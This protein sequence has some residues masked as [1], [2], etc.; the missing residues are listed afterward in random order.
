LQNTH[1]SVA[2]SVIVP[3]NPWLY[4]TVV[5]FYSSS[6]KPNL[7]RDTPPPNR[8]LPIRPQ[9]LLLLP[10]CCGRFAIQLSIFQTFQPAIF[11][12]V[13][14]AG[15]PVVLGKLIGKPRNARTARNAKH[16]AS[17]ASPRH[18]K[19]STGTSSTPARSTSIRIIVGL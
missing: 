1:I 15:T 19:V 11:P 8:A 14:G 7:K 18:P 3:I 16:S 5:R 6:Q 17:T 9:Q 2:G 10:N 4:F 13:I 12:P